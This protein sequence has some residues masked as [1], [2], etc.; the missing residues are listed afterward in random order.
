MPRETDRLRDIV[1]AL[2]GTPYG[3]VLRDE[4]RRRQIVFEA[5]AGSTD[6]MTR[7][8]GEQL[9]SGATTPRELLQHGDYRQFLT[10]SLATAQNL[11]LDRLQSDIAA[12]RADERLTGDPDQDLHAGEPPARRED[13]PDKDHRR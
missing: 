10:D 11:D 3:S 8:V 13:E 9:L 6:P 5:M 1:D 4:R 7:E 12:A 2:D